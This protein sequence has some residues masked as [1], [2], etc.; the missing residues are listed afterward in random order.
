MHANMF[1]TASVVLVVYVPVTRRVWSSDTYYFLSAWDV[2]E[3]QIQVV[4]EYSGGT[5]VW[6]WWGHNAA[7]K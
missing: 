5:A 6:V 2:C 7:K 3:Y 1:P 4:R